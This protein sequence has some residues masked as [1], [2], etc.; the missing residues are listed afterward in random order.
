[1]KNNSALKILGEFFILLISL[2]IGDITMGSH[3]E[4]PDFSTYIM[5]VIT[6]MVLNKFIKPI[7][8]IIG[9]PII[10]LTLG[11][12]YILITGFILIICTFLIPYFF[13]ESYLYALLLSLIITFIEIILHTLTPYTH[14]HT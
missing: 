10:L 3:V 12:G 9:L 4:I 1:M 11:I 13:I 5:I 8:L 14:S 7:L 6:L 2:Y